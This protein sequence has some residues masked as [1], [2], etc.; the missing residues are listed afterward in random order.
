MASF[1]VFD[2]VFE[3]YRNYL[4]TK[5]SAEINDLESSTKSSHGAEHKISEFIKSDIRGSIHSKLDHLKNERKISRCIFDS[6]QEC[7]T[8]LVEVL[9][10]RLKNVK[11][12]CSNQMNTVIRRYGLQVLSAN[13]RLKELVNEVFDEYRKSEK[14]IARRHNHVQFLGKVNI[15]RILNQLR[16]EKFLKRLCF[17]ISQDID[18]DIDLLGTKKQIRGDLPKGTLL[19][20]RTDEYNAVADLTLK[21][22]KVD[23]F[24]VANIIRIEQVGSLPP[25][26][27]TDHTKKSESNHSS[28]LLIASTLGEF[29]VLLYNFH[30]SRIRAHAG[31]HCCTF[32][33][34]KFNPL[35]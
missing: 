29:Q 25:R 22:L 31:L 34:S 6:N 13:A 17:D 11:D 32:L 18:P 19:T 28:T 3:A 12:V 33:H 24:S 30:L 15:I 21:R 9:D 16:W 1:D 2:I 26:P 8:S 23:N 35:S 7:L 27:N 14:R 20:P 10:S 5:E 4:F